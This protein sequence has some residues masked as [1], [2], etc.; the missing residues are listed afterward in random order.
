MPTKKTKCGC[1]TGCKTTC[2]CRKQNIGCSDNCFCKG[3]CLNENNNSLKR[4]L[5]N[6]DLFEDA[7]TGSS[8]EDKENQ[9]EDPHTPKKIKYNLF[10]YTRSE[11]N[12]PKKKLIEFMSSF[13]AQQ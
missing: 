2:G 5:S 3:N 9:E 11:C 13:Q 8:E 7:E 12:F 1:K 10:K 6:Q 4:V